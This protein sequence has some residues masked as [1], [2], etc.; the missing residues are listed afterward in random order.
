MLVVEFLGRP[1]GVGFMIHMRFQLFD[2]AM[3]LAYAISFVLVM[4]AVEPLIL[5]PWERRARPRRAA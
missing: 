5:Q 3:A 4:L 1:D 2:V